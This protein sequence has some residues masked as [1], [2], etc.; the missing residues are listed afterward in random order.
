MHY[1]MNEGT[2]RWQMSTSGRLKNLEQEIEQLPMDHM[3]YLMDKLMVQIKK[4]ASEQSTLHWENLYGYGKGIWDED[5]QDYVNRI[6]E[7]R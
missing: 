1:G 4:K 7:D 6:R 5:A 3:I 2:R